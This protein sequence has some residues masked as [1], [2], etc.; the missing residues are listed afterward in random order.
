MLWTP[1]TTELKLTSGLSSAWLLA[2][3]KIQIAQ[4]SKKTQHDKR[5]KEH[6][7]RVGDRVVIH[8]PSAVT[9]KAWKLARPFHGPYRV[10]S[11]TSTKIEARLVD[12]PD[13]D[14]IF[15]AISTVRP[16]YPELLNVTWTGSKN[17]IRKNRAPRNPRPASAKD[18]EVQSPQP[19]GP[20]TRSMARKL[21]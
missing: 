17:K 2:R 19:G 15:V 3:E 5:A 9:G 16:C 1:R 8:M 7:F 4:A 14:P 12:H 18:S 20:V 6:Q 11:V 13:V 10:L 21:I